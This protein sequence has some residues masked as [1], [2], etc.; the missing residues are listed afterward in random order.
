MVPGVGLSISYHRK[1]VG[2]V[3]VTSGFRLLNMPSV[4]TRV[5]R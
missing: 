1:G 3:S 2:A 4:A 5:L